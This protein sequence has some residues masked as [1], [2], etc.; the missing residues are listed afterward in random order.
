MAKVGVDGWEIAAG[1]EVFFFGQFSSLILLSITCSQSQQ[2]AHKDLEP[3]WSKS[4]LMDGK[5][6][7][8]QKYSF[9]GNSVVLF[10]FL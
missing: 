1:T 8:G 10:C 5:L 3:K 6:R 7:Q 9:L 4:V 2:S